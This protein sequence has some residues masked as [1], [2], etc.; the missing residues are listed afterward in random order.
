MRTHSSGFN[1]ILP[2]DITTI[3]PLDCDICGYLMKNYSDV[4]SYR[5]AGCCSLCF[6]KWAELDLKGWQEGQRPS[7]EEIEEEKKKRESY[8]SILV[9]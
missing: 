2:N 8:P 9:R 4:V 6:Y 1:V 7:A 5:K 3:V